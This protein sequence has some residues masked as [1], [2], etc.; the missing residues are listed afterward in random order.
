MN[1]VKV[2]NLALKAGLLR[3]QVTQRE[4][5]REIIKKILLLKKPKKKKKS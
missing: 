5:K 1:L 2:E 4:K 3:N